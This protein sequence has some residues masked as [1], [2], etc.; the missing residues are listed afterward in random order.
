[1]QGKKERP[2]VVIHADKHV[3]AL[4]GDIL[5]LL[6]RAATETIPPFR[7]DKASDQLALRNAQVRTL[8][9]RS[10]GLLQWGSHP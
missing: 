3:F 6:D 10:Q 5:A 4:T 1:M 7:D 8:P 2:S 9:A